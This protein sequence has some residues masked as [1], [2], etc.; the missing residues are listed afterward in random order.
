MLTPMVFKIV[1]CL[2]VEKITI[3]IYLPI[4]GIHSLAV[5]NY[6]LIIC[7]GLDVKQLWVF[8]QPC[9]FQKRSYDLFANIRYIQP[10]CF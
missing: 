1:R 4:Y 7:A 6:R 8:T 3:T 5:L 2:A 9:C 10:C